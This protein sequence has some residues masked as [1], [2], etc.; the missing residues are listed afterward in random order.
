MN[1]DW[2]DSK[3]RKCNK[4]ANY[5]LN[6]FKGKYRIKCEY[7]RSKN[8]FSR[9][10]DG[11]FEDIDCYIDCHNAQIFHYGNQILEAYIPSLKRG[12]N[13]IKSIENNL[14]KNIIS[15]IRE[16]DSE[17]TFRFNCKNMTQ[18][19]PYLKPKTSGS[20]ISPFSSKNLPKNKS[21]KIPERDLEEYKIIIE[22]LGKEN[23]IVLT[24]KTNAYIKS[25]ITKKNNWDTIKTDMALKGLN[26]KNYIHS[27]GKWNDYILYLHK[28]LE[29]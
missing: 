8:Q 2:S 26:G 29:L 11:T 10:L 23:I 13:I 17:V 22:K 24:H 20:N 6:K 4:I 18:L 1:S 3:E 21:Y 19:E 27:I 16:S 12:H 28:E 25:L 9:K 15:N 7:D 14:G 5:L